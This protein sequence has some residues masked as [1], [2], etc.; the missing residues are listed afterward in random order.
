LF[1]NPRATIDEDGSREVE[2]Y[3]LRFVGLNGGYV[4]NEGI[5]VC[6]NKTEHFGISVTDVEAVVL[7]KSNRLDGGDL[8][9]VAFNGSK[10][11]KR[12]TL[13]V[14]NEFEL[15]EI[16]K[17]DKTLW[18]EELVVR[19]IRNKLLLTRDRGFNEHDE[20]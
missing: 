9:F 13:W 11:N 12:K 14:D 6:P 8:D 10:N 19:L 1:S 2:C 4:K 18:H 3:L 5:R 17:A 15:I 16:R 7:D 20:S